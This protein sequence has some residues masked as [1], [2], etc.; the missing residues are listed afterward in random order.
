MNTLDFKNFA[1]V[2]NNNTFTQYYYDLKLL[3][4]SL[5][6][7]ENLPDHINQKWIEE[8]LF[9]HGECM[10]YKDDVIGF[11]VAKLTRDG[12]NHQDEPIYAR[13][14]ATGLNDSKKYKVGSECVIIRNN[15]LSLPLEMKVQLFAYRLA[16]ITRT[17]DININAQKT[18]IVIICGDRQ[19]LSLKNVFSQYNGNEPVIYG[20]KSLD[21]DSIKVLNTDAPVVFDKLQ[22]QKHQ[23][24]NEFLTYIGINNANQDKRERLVA[25]EVQA[26]NE[27]VESFFN[28]MLEAR[29]RAVEEINRIWG[30]NISVKKRIELEPNYEGY[31]NDPEG[32]EG[33]NGGS[34]SKGG[35]V[36]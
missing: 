34:Y 7:Y 31:E 20:D 1:K 11:N 29:E 23:V 22:L 36:A 4:L 19:R 5:F 32:Y 3:C 13:P 33:A 16:E 8:K 14:F 17:Q 27:S 10:F 18:P 9:T 25:D 6:E 24:M 12:V 21:I 30:L 2:L 35:E 15:N 26:N 28:V